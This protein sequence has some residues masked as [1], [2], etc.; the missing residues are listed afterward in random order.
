MIPGMLSPSVRRTGPRPARHRLAT[1][2]AAVL[3]L[4][5][6]ATVLALL[7]TVRPSRAA[8]LSELLAGVEA[9]TRLPSAAR[10]DVRIE[11]GEACTASG[12]RA[13]FLGRGDVLFVEIEGGQRA[14]LRP[15]RILIAR[16]GKAAEAGVGEPFGDTDLLLQDL[17]PFTAS[18]LKLPQI[19]D[20]GPAG[21]VV[22]AAPAGPSPYALLVDTI[23]PERRTIVRTL[24][25]RDFVNNLSKTRRDGG[26]VR[27][28]GGLRPGTI[29]V[30]SVRQATRTRLALSWQDAPDA[31]AELFEPGGLEKPSGLRWP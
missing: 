29:E 26:F 2:I 15:G 10:A 4:R 19:S 8:T 16:G 7:A 23:D 24:Y 31:P 14:L 9:N 6:V 11:C 13:I 3:V 1:R 30:E 27:I 20:E 22:T 17:V 21:V 12:R 25:Y 18:S 28:A 5:H